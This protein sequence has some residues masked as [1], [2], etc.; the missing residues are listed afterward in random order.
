MK[1]ID[2]SEIK[3]L[4]RSDNEID[5]HIE[6]AKWGM[7]IRG[8]CGEYRLNKVYGYEELEAMPDT[9]T[10]EILINEFQQA[11]KRQLKKAD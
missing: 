6:F 5:I 4:C 10:L 3:N 11:F 1:I 2:I 8:A 7:F 9:I